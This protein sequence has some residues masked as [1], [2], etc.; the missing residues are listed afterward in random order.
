MALLPTAGCGGCGGASAPSAGTQTATQREAEEKKQK[1]AD[2]AAKRPLVVEPL[3]PVLSEGLISPTGQGALRLAKPGHW[4]AT[5]QRMTATADNVEGR[6]AVAVVN[7]RGRTLALPET[8]FALVS[9][10]PAVLAKGR[11]KRVLSEVLPPAAEGRL[12][13]RSSL[14]A[15]GSVLDERE[16]RWTLMPS[17]QYFMLVLAREP[18][19]Y[20]F[21]K[22][23]DSVRAPYET[24]HGDAGPPH[25]RVVLLDGAK[26]APLPTNPIAWTSVAYVVWDQADVTR[27]LPEQQQALVDWLHWGGRLIISGPDSLRNLRGT[28]LDKYLPVDGG[29]AIAIDSPDLA[30]FSDAWSVRSE[31]KSPPPLGAT[32]PWSGVELSPR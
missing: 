11:T 29:T 7:G 20:A 18:A 4:T 2:E 32:K 22:V 17:H 23:A 25:Y 14:S 31:G 13:V 27:L 26:A 6:T 21:L 24:E 12:R 1:E 5:A 15:G 3:A 9:S 30:P 28:F 16:D 8:P 19:R 10:R